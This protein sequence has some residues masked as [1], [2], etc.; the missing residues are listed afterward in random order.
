M[1]LTCT[2][3]EIKEM[4]GLSYPGLSNLTARKMHTLMQ[5]LEFS[6]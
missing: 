6:S 2:G 3:R 4:V 1:S 5:D